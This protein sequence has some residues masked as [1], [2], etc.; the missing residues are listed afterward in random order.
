MHMANLIGTDQFNLSQIIGMELRN[1][2]KNKKM[3]YS[4]RGEI[5]LFQAI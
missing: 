2:A 4:K 1:T 3:D 5:D